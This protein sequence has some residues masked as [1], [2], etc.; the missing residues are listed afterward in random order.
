MKISVNTLL[1]SA[2]KDRPR[3]KM[4]DTIEF[5]HQ[6]GFEALDVNFCYIIHE[7]NIHEPVLNG[8]WKKN[9]DEV[10]DRMNRFDIAVSSSHAPFFNVTGMDSSKVE[11]YSKGIHQAIEAGAYIGAP[12]IVLHPQNVE[13]KTDVKLSIEFLKPF[14]EIARKHGIGIAV[15]NMFETRAEQLIE[16]VNAL[17]DGVGVCWDT[18]HANLGGFNQKTELQALG[19]HVKVLHIHDN[20]GAKDNHNTPYIGN[21]NWSEFMEALHGIGFQGDLNLEVSVRQM[22][23]EVR[24]EHAKFLVAVGKSLKSMIPGEVQRLNKLHEKKSGELASAA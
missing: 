23:E 1:Q 16:I 6:A 20:Y 8:N 14:C 24:L 12:W 15:E 19:S 3:F 9:L 10:M 21:I 13:K 18:G 5:F 11:R 7:G 22:P 17:G 4:A 2:R